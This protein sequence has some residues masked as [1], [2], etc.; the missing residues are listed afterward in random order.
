MT[1][2]KKKPVPK[3]KTPVP[4]KKVARKKTPTTPRPKKPVEHLEPKPYLL[5]DKYEIVPAFEFKGETFFMHRDP[6][7]TL[8]GRG[9]TSMMFFEELLM[10]CDVNYLKDYCQAVRSIFSDPKRIDILQL[11]T[12]TQHLE[13]RVNFLAAIPEH[14][15]KMASVVFFTENECPFRYDQEIGM[16]RVAEWKEAPGMYSFFLRT[17]LSQLIPCLQLP[18]ANSPVFLQVQEKIAEIHLKTLRQ[19]LSADLYGDAR[20]N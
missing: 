8:A 1:A 3:K 4:A 15:Y 16:K 11:A 13:E 12:I 17:P 14:V 9:L 20:K 7:N 5:F 19:I 2:T 18:E 6:L 10:R